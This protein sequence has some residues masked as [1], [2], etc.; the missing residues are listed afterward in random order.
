MTCKDH[1]APEPSLDG[2]QMR[3]HKLEPWWRFRP[4]QMALASG[5]VLG[6]GFL[7][8]KTG[9]IPESAALFFYLAAIPIGA[10]FWVREGLE[11]LLEERVIGIEFLMA[12]AAAGAGALGLWEE[13]AF[14][15]F[16]YGAAEALE[17]YT[18]DR[19]RHAIRSLLDL[20]PAEARVLR[21][22]REVSIA[23]RDLIPDDMFLVR[24]GERIPTDGVVIDGSG[25]IDE[26]PV[27]G[28]HVPAD[29]QPGAQVFAGSLNLTGA[30]RVRVTSRFED[31]TL[32]KIILL[33]ETAQARKGQAQLF[34]ERFGRRYSPLVLITALGLLAVPAVLGLELGVWAH[35]AVVLLVAA[36]P[37]ALVMSTP[38]AIAAGIGRAGRHGVLVKGGMTLERLGRLKVVALDKTGTLTRGE[39]VVTDVVAMP[40][41]SERR[42]LELAAS[43]EHLSEHP[44]AKAIVR[45]AEQVGCERQ[46]AEAF[47]ALPGAGARATVAGQAVVI[48][49]PSF[50]ADGG[51]DMRDVDSLAEP[52]RHQGK[53]LVA[54]RVQDR[55]LGLLALQDQPRPEAA[56]AV[57]ALH[58]LG[59]KLVM[60]TGDNQATAEAVASLVGIDEV[61]A[62]LR[63]D[64]KV[65]HVE[66]L[67]QRYGDVAMV[68]DGINDAPALAAATVGVAMGTAG[69]D[70]AIEAAD[71]ALMGDDL[72]KLSYV[73]HLGRQA[74]RISQQ[75]IVFS[76][77]VLGVL[78]PAALVGALT[79]AVAVLAHE[80]SEILAVLN[81]T[82]AGRA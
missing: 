49:R 15:V 24:P 71:V 42:L 55:I 45:H 26:S 4:L 6:I 13:A 51:I 25:A 57:Q 80:V 62:E 27:T 77:V 76:L 67:R 69:T 5:L 33:V 59:I 56:R 46:P 38:V 17:E 11:E 81:G 19:T 32:S 58:A 1:S 22:G 50:H 12:A 72:E 41:E 40:G 70:A 68:G 61:H 2:S 39:P 14:L 34:I 16:L 9:T 47:E 29:K 74:R 7:L 52:L 54:V 63:P 65:Q 36:A 73:V 21:D 66:A 20:A 28:E 48:A 18:V 8:E 78:V 31:N 37:C 82:R 79:V 53:T 43:V 60:L 30:L 23:A 75:N 64:Q 10:Y 3:E 35:R 44:L